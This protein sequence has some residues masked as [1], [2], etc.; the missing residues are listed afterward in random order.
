ML[1]KFNMK[2]ASQ[3]V[4]SAALLY[5]L[6]FSAGSIPQVAAQT[7]TGASQLVS[8]S[9]SA[10]PATAEAGEVQAALENFIR[11]M[12]TGDRNIVW[13]YASEEDQAAFE[14]EAALYTAFAEDFPELT[15]AKDVRVQSFR[16]EGDTPFV[17]VTLRDADGN[18][19]LADMGFWLDDAGD[20]KVVSLDIAPATDRVA[21]L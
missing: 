4:A 7:D 11:G 21:A 10:V 6:A 1:M 8:F 14:T 18:A 15:Q 2:K 12:A 20:W 19:Y 17:K 5:A 3:S 9:S 13:A 16:N